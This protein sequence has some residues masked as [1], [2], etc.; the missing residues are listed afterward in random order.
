MSQVRS[1][2]TNLQGGSGTNKDRFKKLMNF[3]LEQQFSMLSK[4]IESNRLKQ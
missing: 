1:Q 4:M 2:T 3:D